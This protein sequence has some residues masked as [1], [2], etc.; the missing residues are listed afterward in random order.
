MSLKPS[1]FD[2]ADFEDDDE[3]DS[4]HSELGVVSDDMAEDATTVDAAIGGQES[5]EDEDED[6]AMQIDLNPQEHL[7]QPPVARPHVTG[8]LPDDTPGLKL[9]GG[10]RWSGG[11]AQRDA[12]DE[13]GPSSSDES[14]EDEEEQVKKKKK[15]KRKEVEEDL[16]AVMHT[17]APESNADFERL[18]LGS[19]NSSYL[20]IQYMSFQLQLS[21]V[22][23]AR[24]IARRALRTINFREE[25]EKLN[26][27]TALL[28]LE[29]VYGTEES[30]EMVFKE[31]A[32]AN[33]SKTAHLR[34]AVI[35]DEAEKFD[36]RFCAR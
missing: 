7:Y 25:Q 13:G 10:F 26:V 12:D 33:D 31:A 32:R 23:K 21:E 20:W 9:S 28:N 19:P 1:H 17:R 4:E 24:E 34:L 15:R 22:D 27:W 36:V 6:D 35:F 16:T 29:N 30:L 3:S 2:E 5:D 11:E 14:D 8:G 18:L